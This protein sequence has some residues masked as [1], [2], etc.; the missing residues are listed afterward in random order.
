MALF[1]VWWLRVTKGDKELIRACLLLAVAK[2][3]NREA[4]QQIVTEGSMWSS[5]DLLEL[6]GAAGPRCSRGSSWPRGR[7]CRDL[8]RRPRAF[9][10]KDRNDEPVDAWSLSRT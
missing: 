9:P 5:Y 4:P 2:F 10:S 6:E 3:L 7:S 1:L 8:R